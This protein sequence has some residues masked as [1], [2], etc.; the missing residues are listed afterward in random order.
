MLYNTC[1]TAVTKE[2]PSDKDINTK[3]IKHNTNNNEE[4]CHDCKVI[5]NGKLWGTKPSVNFQPF[6]GPV[7]G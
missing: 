4:L 6:R 5:I 7:E 2:N 1:N 3:C